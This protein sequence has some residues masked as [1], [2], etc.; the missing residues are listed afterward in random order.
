MEKRLNNKVETYV[1]DI[2]NNICGKIKEIN[3]N[4]HDKTNQRF[5]TVF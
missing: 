1:N 5:H 2:K 4:E 3:F